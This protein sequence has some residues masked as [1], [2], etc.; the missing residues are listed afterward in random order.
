MSASAP[1]VRPFRLLK[2]PHHPDQPLFRALCVLPPPQPTRNRPARSRPHAQAP[3]SLVSQN[4]CE[5][6]GLEPA[7]PSRRPR[8]G[9]AGRS[10]DSPHRFPD[11]A[12][13]TPS[14]RQ[15]VLH[16]P[17]HDHRHAFPVEPI[18]AAGF[19]PALAARHPHLSTRQGTCH[20]SPGFGSANGR[21]RR[22]RRTRHPGRPHWR[23]HVDLH[24]LGD[25]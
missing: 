14:P 4:P 18:D 9:S 3:K 11:G 10:C 17:A 22:T 5:T 13:A 6:S 25:I 12:A 19:L 15:T 20:Q 21:N 23:T 16:R 24:T 8:S 1:P 2:T 7:V